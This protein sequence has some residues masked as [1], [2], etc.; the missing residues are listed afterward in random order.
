MRNK[1]EYSRFLRGAGL[2]LGQFGQGE[3]GSVEREA[4]ACCTPVVAYDKYELKTTNNLDKLAIRLLRDQNF[5]QEYV[6]RN[7]NYAIKHFHSSAKYMSTIL[8]VYED[9]LF[10]K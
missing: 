10:N 4:M 5:R 6:K 9:V 2:V 1:Q 7:Y 3:M 8:K